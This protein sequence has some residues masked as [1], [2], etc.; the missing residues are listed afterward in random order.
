MFYTKDDI[1]R[2]EFEKDLALFTTKELVPFSFIN[3]LF[4]KV[5]YEIKSS[6]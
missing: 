6:S 1:H 2:K 3:L 5:I 4:K